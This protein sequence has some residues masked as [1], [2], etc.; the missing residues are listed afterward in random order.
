MKTTVL[1]YL[2]T[3]GCDFTYTELLGYHLTQHRSAINYQRDALSAP[4][5]FMCEMLEKVKTGEFMPLAHRNEVFP[6]RQDR[7]C[8]V[9][10]VL[11]KT[12]MHLQRVVEPF[13]G[14]SF[15]DLYK[16]DTSPGRRKLFAMMDH[17]ASENSGVEHQTLGPA[18]QA[19]D[20]DEPV[21]A[22]VSLSPKPS[23]KA[24]VDE[25]AE[26]ESDGSLQDD[27]T[28]SCSSSAESALVAVV[29]DSDPTFRLQS[30]HAV[31]EVLYRHNRTKMSIPHPRLLAAESWVTRMVGSTVM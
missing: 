19:D 30:R 24:P 22:W 6:E 20:P 7:L 4:I 23:L 17:A 13:L 25:D 12:G 15:E 28:D 8:I 1:T 27:D 26:R 9:D 18:D 29:R 3:M 21:D 14:C 31:P 5:R 10:Q 16:E 11:H 2:G